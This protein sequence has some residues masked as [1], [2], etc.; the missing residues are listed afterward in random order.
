MVVNLDIFILHKS[1]IEWHPLDRHKWIEHYNLAYSP[2]RSYFI[3][4]SAANFHY[5]CQIDY[6]RNDFTEWLAQIK[7]FD[8]IMCTLDRKKNIQDKFNSAVSSDSVSLQFL[9]DGFFLL[10]QD[11]LYFI[12]D[13]DEE[14][15]IFPSHAQNLISKSNEYHISI[16]FVVRSTIIFILL[17]F[18]PTLSKRVSKVNY[19]F[20][21]FSR[22]LPLWWL[23]LLTDAWCSCNNY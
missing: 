7:T 5:I 8:E 20:A 11:K 22:P 23:R 1:N 3:F 10:L 6:D 9:S 14:G 4:Q 2:R 21:I 15:N 17:Y 13:T 12:S 16:I 19:L 18:F